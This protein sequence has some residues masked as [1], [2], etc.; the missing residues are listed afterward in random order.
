L[1]CATISYVI[2]NK[3]DVDVIITVIILSRTYGS[4][5]V[6]IGKKTVKITKKN[7]AESTILQYATSETSESKPGS[8]FSVSD[9]S[10]QLENLILLLDSEF[11]NYNQEFEGL[12]L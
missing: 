5:V 11:N 8:L 6:L 9:G 1:P 2:D 10:L 7:D 3:E 12:S 4:D